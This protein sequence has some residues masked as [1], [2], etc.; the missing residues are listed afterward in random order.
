M[1]KKLALSIGIFFILLILF[2]AVIFISEY[3]NM[4]K[5]KMEYISILE[6]AYDYRKSRLKIWAINLILKFLFPLLF[7]TTGLSKRIGVFA[8]GNGRGLFLTGFL[9]VIIFFAI[10]LLFSLPISFYGEFILKHRYDLSNQSILRWLE[11]VL[12][13]FTLNILI[14]SLIIW[15]PYYLIYKHPN[16]WWLYL[17]LLSIP[18]IAFITFISPMYIDPIFNKYTSIKDEELGKEIQKLLQKANIE[19]AQIYKVDKSRDTKEMNAYMTGIF[20]SKRIVLWDTTIKKLEKDEIL[21]VTAHEIGHYIKGHIWKSIILGGLFSIFLIYLIYRTSNW[22]LINSNGIFG[23]SRLYDIASLPLILLILNFYLFLA[24]PI[25]NLIS[26]HMEREADMIEI[27]LTKNKEAA[28]STML[29]LNESNLSIPR[30]SKIYEVWYYTHP[31]TEDRIKFFE[32]Y[33]Y[34]NR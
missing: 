16:R 2:I 8:E 17:G 15:F 21:S 10:D 29:K 27:E 31:T 26:R 22:V 14:F 30:P 13:N 7:L 32:D 25:M 23:F 28:I 34:S 6:M 9:Y 11:L 12:K 20:K 4:N 5:L 3:R 19:E 1:N 33:Q 24:N 18:V